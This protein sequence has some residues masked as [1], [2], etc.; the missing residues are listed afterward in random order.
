M[1]PLNI[2]ILE[3]GDGHDIRDTSRKWNMEATKALFL[4]DLALRIEGDTVEV[5][6][7]RFGDP[8]ST[9]LSSVVEE[10]SLAYA[11]GELK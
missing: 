1:K 3:E 10:V 5:V 4:A 6:K 11:E 7:D 9:H 2:L 8:R